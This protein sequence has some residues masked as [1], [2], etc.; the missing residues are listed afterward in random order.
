[1]RRL[2]HGKFFTLAAEFTEED[3]Q[4][5]MALCEPEDEDSGTVVERSEPT[6]SALKK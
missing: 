6:A 5:M 4:Q 1:M 3:L 2:L